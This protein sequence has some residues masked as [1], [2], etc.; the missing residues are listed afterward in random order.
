[1]ARI[2]TLNGHVIRLIIDRLGAHG[3]IEVPGLGLE[4]VIRF[5]NDRVPL[6]KSNCQTDRRKLFFHNR[7]FGESLT[8]LT[9]L[10]F[11]S[12]FLFACSSLSYSKS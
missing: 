6:L 7:N 5:E 8:D 11:D 1:M 12:L 9:M 4:P 3:G 2:P 10:Y